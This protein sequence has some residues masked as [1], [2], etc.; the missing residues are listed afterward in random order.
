MSDDGQQKQDR[1]DEAAEDLGAALPQVHA[2]LVE[3][4]ALLRQLLG[5]VNGVM[6]VE[7]P[8]DPCDI[9]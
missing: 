6:R 2:A 3:L 5:Y 8:V 1:R 9:H 7:C 4:F